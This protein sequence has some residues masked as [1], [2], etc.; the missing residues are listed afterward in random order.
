M[1]NENPNTGGG[2]DGKK[3]K[4]RKKTPGSKDARGSTRSGGGGGGDGLRIIDDE[5]DM[6][7]LN[8]KKVDKA[9]EEEETEGVVC[10]CSCVCERAM[11]VLLVFRHVWRSGSPFCCIPVLA[12]CPFVGASAEVIC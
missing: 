4:R 9:W 8:K 10:V 6:A 3:K 12:W 5:A 11:R 2:D 1:P 7:R